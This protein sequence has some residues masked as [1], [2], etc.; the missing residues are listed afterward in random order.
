MQAQR[1]RAL[2]GGFSTLFVI[3]AMILYPEYAFQAS[4]SGLKLFLDVVFPSLL[5]FFILSEVFSAYGMVH[6]LGVFFEPVMRPLFNVPGVGSF[7]LSMGLAAGY[8]MDAVLTAK[9]RRQGLCTA[10]EGE[11]LLAFTNTADPLF[12]L[13][14][15][16]VG[17]FQAPALG[18]VLAA[19]HYGGSLV[20]GLI[21]RFWGHD[22]RRP[23]DVPARRRTRLWNRAV[24]ALLAARAEDGRSLGGIFNDAIREAVATL[25]MIM[26]F[27]V[28]FSV[29]IRIVT[30]MGV[31]GVI[32]WPLGWVLRTVGLSPHLIPGMVQGL[33]EIDLGAAQA[34][35]A[36]AP[37][38]QRVALVSGIV[39]WSGLSVHGQVASV[40]TGTDISMRPYFLA[41]FLHAVVAALLTVLL[42]P[43]LGG[44]LP[45][46]A[47]GGSGLPG[48]WGG[49]ALGAEALVLAGGA[50]LVGAAVV[51]VTRSVRVFSFRGHR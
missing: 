45:T 24:M 31:V 33:F 42:F 49:L 1:V 7:V 16:S 20:V 47:G 37:F 19:A 22:D 18:G 17:M 6:F 8:P 12:L 26:S 14:A 32:T 21:F 10:V 9:F 50:L 44:S 25:F 13:G 29:V 2:A 43:L 28:L 4:A 39:A 5:P 35:H 3:F 23:A 40:L 34:A 11:R 30:V 46:M 48:F 38:L 41:R 27:I 36:Q 51:M 15:V